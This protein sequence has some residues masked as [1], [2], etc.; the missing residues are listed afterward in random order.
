MR[1]IQQRKKHAVAAPASIAALHPRVPGELSMNT[2]LA[3]AGGIIQGCFWILTGTLA[4]LTY[5][6]A[7]TTIF[8]PMR[9]EVF[10]R[11]IDEMTQVLAL[12]VGKGEVELSQDFDIDGVFHANALAMYHRYAKTAFDAEPSEDADLPYSPSNCPRS[13]V[14]PEFL[15]LADEHIISTTKG[16]TPKPAKSRQWDYKHAQIHLTK[17]HIDYIDSV[18]IRLANPLLPSRLCTSMQS[19]LKIVD[20]SISTIFDAMDWAAPQMP[21]KYP[22]FETFNEASYGWVRAEYIRRL[23]DIGSL[24][25]EANAI[26]TFVRDYFATDRLLG[27]NDRQAVDRSESTPQSS[28]SG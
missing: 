7:R 16:A 2:V 15:K 12:F 8:Q 6:H 26:S 17:K 23:R 25:Q 1:T 3:N 14:K 20:E 11:Q 9:T 13:I 18:R 22:D 27:K 24:E 4:L 21:K 19:I 5:R 28:S 10:K